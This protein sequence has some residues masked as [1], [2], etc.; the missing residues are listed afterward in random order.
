MGAREHTHPHTSV[1][2]YLLRR[3]GSCAIANARV[4]VVAISTFIVV[5]V[6]SNQG[7]HCCTRR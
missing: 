4:T 3:R 6:V 7:I 2:C 1:G 5:T